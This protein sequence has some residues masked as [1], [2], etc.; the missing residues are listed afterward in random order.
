ML[1]H[2][3]TVEQLHQI[4]FKASTLQ[5]RLAFPFQ[6]LENPSAG[7]I[8]ERLEKWSKTVANL[9]RARFAKRLAL[10]GHNL[11]TIRPYLAPDFPGFAVPS[12]EI[13]GWAGLFAEMVREGF[14]E[15]PTPGPVSYG[16]C[17]PTEPLPFEDVAA[18]L[19]NFAI[20]K[21]ERQTGLNY[22]LL[23]EA[24]RRNLARYLLQMLTTVLARPLYLEFIIYRSH[25][26]TAFARLTGDSAGGNGLYSRFC[27]ELLAGRLVEVFEEYSRSARRLATLVEFWLE[28]ATEFIDRLAADLPAI[29]DTFNQGQ[30]P[31]KVTALEPGGSDRHNRGRSVIILTFET[32]LKLVYK[33][34]PLELEEAFFNLCTWYN[35]HKEPALPDLKT[36]RTLLRP[37]YGWVEFAENT[38][39]QAEAEAHRFF[40]RSGLLLGLFYLLR[41][42]DFHCENIIACGEYPVPVDLETLLCPDTTSPEGSPARLY[43]AEEVAGRGFGFVDADETVL[44]ISFLPFWMEEGPGRGL[45]I[46]GLGG[47]QGQVANYKTPQWEALNTDAMSLGF[48]SARVGQSPNL[49]Q[50]AGVFL[51][52]DDYVAEII[53]GFEAAY[54]F[55]QQNRPTLLSESGPLS[56]FAHLRTRHILRNSNIYARLLDRTSKAEFLREGIEASLAWDGLCR[57]FLHAPDKP[58]SWAIVVAEQQALAQDDIPVFYVPANSTELELWSGDI[59]RKFFR[60]PGFDSV[61]ERVRA[62]RPA[63]MARQTS[64]I[65]ASFLARQAGTIST[66][67]DPVKPSDSAVSAKAPDWQELAASLRRE[68]LDLAGAIT[69]QAFYTPSGAPSWFCLIHDE[70]IKRYQV[71][72]INYNFYGGNLGIA[73]FL[74]ALAKYR[75]D[76]NFREMALALLAPSRGWLAQYPA[77]LQEELP[78][79]GMDGLGALVYS[80]LHI[81]KILKDESLV[82]DAAKVAELLTPAKIGSDKALD[83]LAGSAGASLALLS[84]YRETGRAGILQKAIVCGDHLLEKQVPTPA[85]GAAWPDKNGRFLAGLSHGAAGPAYALAQ[86]F[87]HTGLDRFKLAFQAGLDY[88]RRLFQPTAGN[89]PDLRAEANQTG[90]APG[91]ANQWCHG[92][93]GIGFSRLG[94]L[95][96]FGSTEMKA[97]IEAAVKLTLSQELAVVDHLCC[98]N[99]GQISFLFEAGRKLARPDWVE[100]GRDRLAHLLAQSQA[101][102]SYTFY[103]KLPPQAFNPG[104][105]QGAAGIGYEWLRLAEADL[106]LPNCLILE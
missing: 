94:M 63:D 77:S 49:P 76:E 71:S 4:I 85:G 34:K 24:A 41:G 106:L 88:E 93:T 35:R 61:L 11:T 98:G 64:L 42:A 2:T 20:Q 14:P 16:C 68:A 10:D 58:A 28:A 69:S 67:L 52:P 62:L 7:V 6:P 36:L 60:R 99:A 3:L 92:A 100:V 46:S 81:G 21:L 33:P 1:T 50:L 51:N 44:N 75:P 26:R 25:Q 55:C 13:P 91:F 74:A 38:P 57:P 30:A 23:E 45:D 27:Q 73:F 102:G 86:L 39:C 8:D 97:E 29:A 72:S 65:R 70:T 87:H 17:D 9:D 15:N 101:Q 96:V 82:E 5:E 40:V 103:P 37:G 59:I 95:E 89:W 19:V 43:T 54:Q 90:H 18:P 12:L 53:T 78:I 56:D 66:I 48:T 79:G 104:F 47:F 105:M 83:L 84:L 80:W 22:H 31:G 32:G